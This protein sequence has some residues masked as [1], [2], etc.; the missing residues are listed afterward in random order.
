[1]NSGCP[2]CFSPKQWVLWRTQ[3]KGVA[4]PKPK[5]F[6]EDCT[7]EHQDRMVAVKRCQHPETIFVRDA[8]GF[9]TGRRPASEET[10]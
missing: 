8:D 1:M 6:C 10:S 4:I 5:S 3:P 7:P 2:L 9:I